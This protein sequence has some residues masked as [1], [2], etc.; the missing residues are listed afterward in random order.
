MAETQE[1]P[2]KAAPKK[3][4]PKK[5]AAPKAPSFSKEEML[6]AINVAVQSAV[7]AAAPAPAPA[8]APEEKKAELPEAKYSGSENMVSVV[9]TIFLVLGILGSIV[10]V[11]LGIV[12]LSEYNS[13]SYYGG[14]HSEGMGVTAIIYGVVILLV[15]LLQFGMCKLYV[16]MSYRLTSIDKV[17]RAK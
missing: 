13:Y 2:K 16:N 12:S 1:T 15:S 17:L 9:A 6:E 5:A 4:A 10:L 3:A 11:I 8:P 7:K 14:Y